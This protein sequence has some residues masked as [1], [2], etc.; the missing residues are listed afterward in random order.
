MINAIAQL[1]LNSL[2]HLL[3]LF[4]LAGTIL[5]VV[6][7][8][9]LPKGVDPVTG[10]R[11]ERYRAPVPAFIP[12]GQVIGTTELRQAVQTGDMVLINVYPP[13]GLGPDPLSG[14]W[15]ISEHHE[16]IEGSTWLP[17]VGR[18]HIEVDATRYFQRHLRR[19]TKGDKNMALVFYCTADC[20]Q[21]WNAARRAISWGYDNIFWYPEGIDGWLDAGFELVAA[22]PENFLE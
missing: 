4:Y 9:T 2:R 15:I 13:K 16:H 19:L 8:E 11:M 18:G 10:Y 20:W 7:A 14:D 1:T 21:S 22:S 3:P 12:G 6:A 17:D 5:P